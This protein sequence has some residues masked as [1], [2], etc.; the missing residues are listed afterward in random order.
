VVRVSRERPWRI[1]E[2]RAPVLLLSLPHSC[3]QCIERVRID[4]GLLARLTL[5]ELVAQ[6]CRRGVLPDPVQ[7]GGP[8]LCTASVSERTRDAV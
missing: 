8:A 1:S 4:H 3:D 5:A 7:M 2:K 6:Q